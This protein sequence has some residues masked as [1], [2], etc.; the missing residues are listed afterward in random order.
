MSGCACP[1]CTTLQYSPMDKKYV[2]LFGTC[3]ECDQRQCMLGSLSLEKLKKQ[4]KEALEK[5]AGKAVSNG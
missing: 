2:E 5:S 3:R 4:K 1:N